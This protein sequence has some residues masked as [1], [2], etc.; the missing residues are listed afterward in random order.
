M[1]VLD[2]AL[3][4][5]PDGDAGEICLGGAGV[6]RG[7]LGRPGATA[8]AFVPDP[9]DPGGRLYRT[10]DLGRRRADGVIEFLGRIDRQVKIRGFRVEPGEVEAFLDTCDGVQSA[11][12]LAVP[13]PDGEKRL[14]AYAVTD[15][16]SGTGAADLRAMAEDRLPAY[17]RPSYYVFVEELPLD[18][19]GKVDRARLPEPWRT[20]GGLG[21][22]PYEPAR[23]PVEAVIAALLA[24]SLGLDQVGR[25][26]DFFAHGGT[27]LQSVQV[28]DRLRAQGHSVTSREFFGNPTVA[29][30]AGLLENRQMA[31]AGSARTVGSAARP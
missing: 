12:V 19:N 23:T 1:V 16:D 26:D 15:A 22:A 2:S 31:A 30:L 6:V 13:A 28:L 3:R 14:V 29:D 9:A 27:S 11:V 17:A 7:Y 8:A 25:D 24:E 4:P 10:G 5:V 21:L 18:P 20:R